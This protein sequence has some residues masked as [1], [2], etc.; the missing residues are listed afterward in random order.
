MV[1]RVCAWCGAWMGVV[2]GPSAGEPTSTTHGLCQGCL[3]GIRTRRRRSEDLNGD[4]SSPTGPGD[5]ETREGRLK[6]RAGGKA[7]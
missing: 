5:E 1:F 4:A 7:G 6:R 3:E 2:A